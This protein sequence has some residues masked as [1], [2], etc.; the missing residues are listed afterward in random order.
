MGKKRVAFLLRGLPGLGHVM[1]GISVAEAL[2]EKD[3]E[4][5]ILTYGNGIKIAKSLKF[6]VF[7]I[8][9]PKS[10]PWKNTLEATL[11]V[12]PILKRIKPNLIFVDGELDSVFL[13]KGLGYKIALC[14][15]KH[16]IDRDFPP[17]S[18]YSMYMDSLLN[19]VDLVIVHGIQSP[20]K[21]NEKI[22]FVGP[23]VRKCFEKEEK[24][25][26]SVAIC[27]GFENTKKFKIMEKKIGEIGKKYGLKIIYL[28]KKNKDF[29]KDNSIL[30]RA[31]VIVCDGGISTISEALVMG[32]PLLFIQVDDLE[33]SKNMEIAKNL[34]FG[35]LIEDGKMDD[36]FKKVLN[37]KVKNIKNGL[38]K[39][40]ELLFAL[41]NQK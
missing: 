22:N 7:D 16:Y 28:G 3:Y 12:L 14:T 27:Y 8:K 26:D 4:C 9:Q 1:P 39:T 19:Y 5:Y 13:L 11:D 23:L 33:K 18:K 10:T 41:M 6:K 24:E 29:Q 31:R 38:E 25:K 2:R 40:L 37:M 15:T 35:E 32:I 20:N 36:T 17:Y 30:L 34:G 21:I